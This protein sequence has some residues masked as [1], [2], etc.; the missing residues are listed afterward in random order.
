MLKRMRRG[1]SS[2][3]DARAREEAA[4]AHR[5]RRP[6]HDVHR[7][8]PGRNRRRVRR[9]LRVRRRVE[10][11]S[12]RRV[13]RTQIQPGTVWRCCP[14]A[15]TPS[16]RARAK[17]SSWRSSARSA[18]RVTR[19]W[20]ARKSTSSSK[21][22]RS[23][24]TTCSKAAGTARRPASTASRTSPHGEA[25][26]G[27]I[28]KARV[29]QAADYDLAAS[30]DSPAQERRSRARSWAGPF[31]PLATSA[32]HGLSRLGCS[33]RHPRRLRSAGARRR[34]ESCVDD[35]TPYDTKALSAR[36]AFLASEKLDGPSRA[37]TATNQRETTSPRG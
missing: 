13:H 26:P 3:R 1:H 10:V 36:I 28:V 31:A 14:T 9:A 8:S 25:K 35:G 2:A 4:R 32:R 18:A 5:Q 19:R 17:R 33:Y 11:R 15:S 24:R 27:D 16:S 37:P 21:A 30:L 7:R 6:A 23:Q 34:P 29:T 12:R 20:S 22:S